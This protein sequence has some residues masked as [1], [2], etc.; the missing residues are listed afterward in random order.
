MLVF[1]QNTEQAEVALERGRAFL[2][3][4]EFERAIKF[5]E[6][7]QQLNPSNNTAALRTCHSLHLDV[8]MR[9]YCF[10]ACLRW[11][12][13]SDAKSQARAA[14]DYCGCALTSV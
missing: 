10:E 3:Q 5:L 4:R 13:V 9:A 7:S 1:L 8:H 14:R 6:K 11:C 12:A 2:R